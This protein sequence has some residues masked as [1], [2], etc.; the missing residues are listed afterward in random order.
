MKRKLLI[1]IG[2]L[3]IL[4]IITVNAVSTS[5][6]A[7]SVPCLILGGLLILLGIFLGSID[8]VIE[9]NNLLNMIYKLFKF[10]VLLLIFLVTVIEII[11]IG[12]PKHNTEDSDYIMVL[13]AGLSNGNYPSLTL[14]YRLDAAEK[15][16][17]DLG[18]SKKIVV[19]GGKGRDERLS[20]AE[21][22]KNYLVDKGIP[23]NMILLE[24]K[25]STTSEN[26]KFS[27]SVIESDSDKK[28]EDINVKIVTTD[29]HAF[30]SK[31][32]AKKN[33][34]KNISNYSSDT[35]WYLIPINYFREFFAV[36]KSIIFD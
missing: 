26:F 7:F 17:K 33:G 6:I 28:I 24:D 8:N 22:M 27:K 32:I 12:Y 14:S 15:V 10:G 4:Y 30:R 2:T 36:V 5:K 25:S 9:G 11:I 1:T 31:I 3:I 34:Y 21:A 16:F 18:E 29:F 13:G 35:V 19:S 20:E 23:E